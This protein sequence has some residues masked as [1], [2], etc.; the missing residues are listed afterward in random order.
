M[1]GCFSQPNGFVCQHMLSWTQKV[2]SRETKDSEDLLEL[3]CGNCNFTI[4]LSFNFRKVIATEISRSS[5]QAGR[6][7][8]EANDVDN[9]LLVKEAGHSLIAKLLNLGSNVERGVCREMEIG[10]FRESI[11]ESQIERF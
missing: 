6:E 10:V 4:P 5:V 3:Y 1:E 8:L 7:N 2:S 9:V 11:A